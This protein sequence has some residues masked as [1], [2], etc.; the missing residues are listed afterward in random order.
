M[1]SFTLYGGGSFLLLVFYI[2]LGAVVLVG[3]VV[4]GAALASIVPAFLLWLSKSNKS[5]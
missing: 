2:G 5:K 1:K 4:V 3:F